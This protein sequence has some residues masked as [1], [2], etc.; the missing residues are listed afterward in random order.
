MYPSEPTDSA[1]ARVSAVPALGD[2]GGGY[3]AGARFRDFAH[4]LD[5]F[6]QIFGAHPRGHAFLHEFRHVVGGMGHDAFDEPDVFGDAVL[7][8]VPDAGRSKKNAHVDPRPCRLAQKRIAVF[9]IDRGQHGRG[10]LRGPRPDELGVLTQGLFRLFGFVVASVVLTRSATD[11]SFRSY[12]RSAAREAT[13]AEAASRIFR[14]S[15]NAHGIATQPL[16]PPVGANM[17]I[18]SGRGGAWS[19]F[20]ACAMSSSVML[21]N[22]PEARPGV[23]ELRQRHFSCK[24]TG[25]MEPRD[26]LCVGR[27]DGR[28]VGFGRLPQRAELKGEIVRERLAPERAREDPED[29][30]VGGTE[31][32]VLKRA[33]RVVIRPQIGLAVEKPFGDCPSKRTRG[34]P[35]APAICSINA[36]MAS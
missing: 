27:G 9:P 35:V 4:A 10:R 17:S 24:H 11:R 33:H 29:G 22:R 7:H 15:V 14:R 21:T 25:G 16:S 8:R 32:V 34:M 6:G 19:S 28:L 1:R 3:G 20:S 18:P 36:C 2:F 12:A 30:I 5:P 31:I 13:K 26:V 23:P